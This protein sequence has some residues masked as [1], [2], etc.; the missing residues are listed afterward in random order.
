MTESG[1]GD[2]F[3]DWGVA[4]VDGVF[5]YPHAAVGVERLETKIFVSRTW[6]FGVCGLKDLPR[7]DH[8]AFAGVR[9]SLLCWR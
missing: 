4:F 6:I 3:G 2:Q 1:V 5:D 8:H 7:R 9:R